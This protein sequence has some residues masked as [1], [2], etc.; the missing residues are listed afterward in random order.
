[1]VIAAMRLKDVCPLE[2]NLKRKQ[3]EENTYKEASKF[4][5]KKRLLGEGAFLVRL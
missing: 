4:R 2:A 3:S 5:I 1:M